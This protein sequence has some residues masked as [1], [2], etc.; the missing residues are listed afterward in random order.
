MIFSRISTGRLGGFD[1][2]YWESAGPGCGRGWESAGRGWCGPGR[3]A[4]R[5]AGELMGLRIGE[6]LALRSRR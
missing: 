4:R 1:R 3:P 2:D 6:V 5:S